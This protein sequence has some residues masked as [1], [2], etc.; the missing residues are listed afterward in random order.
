LSQPVNALIVTPPGRP[1]KQ[2]FARPGRLGN[3]SHAMEF[4]R[5][6]DFTDC[7]V[8]GADFGAAPRTV[9]MLS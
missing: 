8:A 7:G 2:S 9:L 6:A 3:A 1:L 4:Y 5:S